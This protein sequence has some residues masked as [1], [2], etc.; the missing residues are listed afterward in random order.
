MTSTDLEKQAPAAIIDVAATTK[1]I[2]N[3]SDNDEASGGSARGISILSTFKRINDFLERLHGFESRGITRVP[4][5]ERNPP[6]LLADFQVFVMWFS[7]NVSV[8]NL[9]AGLLGPLVFQ[10]GFLDSALC[11]VFGALLGSASTAYMSIWGPISGNR[12]MVKKIPN[13]PAQ[14]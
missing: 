6:S 4:P 2:G 14:P 11:A 13:P 12:T 8:N 9:T 3:A 5:E 1:S 7:A 10:L